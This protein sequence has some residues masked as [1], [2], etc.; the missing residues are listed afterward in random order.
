MIRFEDLLLHSDDI[1][2]SIAECVGGTANRNH[3][4]ETGTSKNHGS[5]A[6][7]VKAV[8]KTGDLGMRLK[9]LTQPDLHYATEHLDAELMQAFR[10]NLS[11]VNR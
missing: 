6:D 2:Q 1:V 4:V 8:I 11:T 7:F 9:H 3:V 5:G 10:Y